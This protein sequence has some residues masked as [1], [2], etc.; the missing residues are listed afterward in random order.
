MFVDILSYLPPNQTQSYGQAKSQ[1][2]K[3]PCHK[4]N[5]LPSEHQPPEPRS[6]HPSKN[7]ESCNDSDDES[8]NLNHSNNHDAIP[9]IDPEIDF[10]NHV[11]LHENASHTHENKDADNSE[12][13][14]DMTRKIHSMMPIQLNNH[15][16]HEAIDIVNVS[17]FSIFPSHARATDSAHLRADSRGPGLLPCFQ[18]DGTS[19]ARKNFRATV[20]HSTTIRQ[21]HCS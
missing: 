11:F 16:Y 4:P 10:L 20:R 15:Y 6:E 12:L 3:R 21:P 8:D 9:A 2:H 1:S 13:S 7:E 14:P 18:G 5:P 17:P 19:A